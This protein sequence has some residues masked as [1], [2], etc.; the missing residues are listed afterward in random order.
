MLRHNGF[1][2]GVVSVAGSRVFIVF[3]YFGFVFP[4]TGF[5]VFEALW[6]GRKAPCTKG[7][8]VALPSE[9]FEP[10]ELRPLRRYLG[11]FY[12]CIGIWLLWFQLC[13]RNYETVVVVDVVMI[14]H[15]VISRA[16][17]WCFVRCLG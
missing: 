10:L 12:P 14:D 1:R 13:L 9:R 8:Y 7:A 2:S 3:V 4:G 6:S 17:C 16:P 15:G 11:E 5:D